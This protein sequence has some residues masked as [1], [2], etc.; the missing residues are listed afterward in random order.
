[1]VTRWIKFQK[2]S[3]C[4]HTVAWHVQ[5]A[6][7]STHRVI[8]TLVLRLN[9]VPRDAPKNHTIW[10]F[11]IFLFSPWMTITAGFIRNHET[12]SLPPRHGTRGSR[13][14]YKYGAPSVKLLSLLCF[15]FVLVCSLE[16]QK[17]LIQWSLPRTG[18]LAMTSAAITGSCWGTP[19]SWERLSLW[20][21]IA[22][23][24]RGSWLR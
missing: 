24:E 11:T 2:Y 5:V 23:A 6:G 14:R 3:R 13:I 18:V 15:F 21:S 16:I 10:W 7:P 8:P 19:A 12:K 20:R 22:G 9:N 17:F 1:M 4:R